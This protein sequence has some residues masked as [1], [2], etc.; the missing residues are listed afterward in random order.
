MFAARL[1]IR[2][3]IFLDLANT[4]SRKNKLAPKPYSS[5]LVTN[6]LG[7]KMQRR[8][9]CSTTPV[10]SSTTSPPTCSQTVQMT[11]KSAKPTWRTKNRKPLKQKWT[12]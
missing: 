3:L 6:G 12:P 4:I 1:E 7:V 2:S 9:N 11:G 5:K 10:K 8:M